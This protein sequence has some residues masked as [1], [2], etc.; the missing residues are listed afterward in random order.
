MLSTAELRVAWAPPCRGPW[1]QVTLY[2]GGQVSVRPAIVDAVRALNACL[3]AARYEARRRDTGA[4]N[5][6]R[7]TGGTG[8]SLHA[9]G[10]ALDINSSTNPYGRVLRTDMP[11]SMVDSILA[12]R[13]NSRQQVWGWGG[14]YS[15]N[16]DAMHYEIVTSPQHIASGINPATLSGAPVPMPPPQPQPIPPNPAPLPSE[17]DMP[18]SYIRNNQTG[19]VVVV[20]EFFF[21]YVTPP[22]WAFWQFVGG[23]TQDVDD[24]TFHMLLDYHEEVYGGRRS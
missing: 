1:A 4:Y 9:Y 3:M 8:Y 11:R 2:G 5:C 18:A 16:K 19:A 21:R 20:N 23:K 12:I 7:I 14:N 10:I 22:Q 15:G 17:D 6:R 13:T 24:K